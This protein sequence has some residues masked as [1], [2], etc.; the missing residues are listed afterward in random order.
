MGRALSLC[1]EGRAV[2]MSLSWVF[3]MGFFPLSFGAGFFFF[4]FFCFILYIGV[5]CLA[6]MGFDVAVVN[7]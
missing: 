5:I 4:S 1:C 6:W 3:D 2:C 7:E